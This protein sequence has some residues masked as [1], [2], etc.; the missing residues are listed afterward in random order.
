VFLARCDFV[1]GNVSAYKAS[2]PV[3]ERL[4]S[5]GIACWYDDGN[6]D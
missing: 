5:E 1:Q 3:M 6:M 4:E 2:K